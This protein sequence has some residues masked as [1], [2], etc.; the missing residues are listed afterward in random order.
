NRPMAGTSPDTT[1]A[2]DGPVFF[3]ASIAVIAVA[4][5]GT[6][7]TS[8]ALGVEVEHRR[9]FGRGRDRLDHPHCRD[10]VVDRRAHLP[11]LPDRIAERDQLG[12]VALDHLGVVLLVG[13]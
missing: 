7:A 3:A 11:A 5:S 2:A 4:T 12:R 6:L 1:L 10:A 13:P 9:A 8:D